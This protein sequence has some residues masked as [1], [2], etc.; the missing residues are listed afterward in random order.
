MAPRSRAACRRFT[1]LVHWQSYGAL[2]YDVLRLTIMLIVRTVRNRN[3]NSYD[4]DEKKQLVHWRLLTAYDPLRLLTISYGH[5]RSTWYTGT[6]DAYD[7]LRLTAAA[8]G[9]R[10]AVYLL[11]YGLRRRTVPC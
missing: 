10:C 9:L 1:P 8:Y 11:S 4:F 7:S 2:R 3:I 6:Y 5:L